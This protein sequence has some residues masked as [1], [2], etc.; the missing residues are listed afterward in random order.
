M[1]AFKKKER[2]VL[3]SMFDF[4]SCYKH[5]GCKSNYSSNKTGYKF[6]L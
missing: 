1:R 2:R 4:N 6:N 5:I 3:G